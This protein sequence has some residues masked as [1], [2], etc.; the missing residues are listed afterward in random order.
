MESEGVTKSFRLVVIGKKTVES[1][2]GYI[3]SETVIIYGILVLLLFFL[4]LF[5]LGP[6]TL[7]VL[8]QVRAL[9]FC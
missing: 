7:K 5:Y 1:N 6:K 3:E 2:K 9:L 4:Y 8:L